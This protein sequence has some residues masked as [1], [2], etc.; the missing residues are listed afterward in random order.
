M[1]ADAP[2]SGRKRLRI[3][4]METLV[5]GRMAELQ[6]KSTAEIQQ[7]PYVSTEDI[8]LDGRKITLSVYHDQVDGMHRVVVQSFR[9]RWCGITAKVIAKGFLIADDGTRRAL[10]PAELYDFT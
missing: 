2:R 3:E 1:S 8:Q 9:E 4:S 6:K 7:L 5:N 10:T